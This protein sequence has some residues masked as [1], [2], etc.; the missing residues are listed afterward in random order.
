[1][2]ELQSW[3]L[4][5]Y[6]TSNVIENNWITRQLSKEPFGELSDSHL[7]YA[8][9]VVKHKFLVGL[10]S[11]LE[12]SMSRFEKFFRWKYHVNPIVQ[13]ACREHLIGRGANSNS[14]NIKERPIPGDPLWDLIANQNVY[15]IKLYQYIESL[16]E[17]QES[18][19]MGVPDNY[20]SI[21]STCCQCSTATYPPEGFS[22][23]KRVLR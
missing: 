5:K 19:F 6:A 8:I 23:P 14:K 2:P 16:Y 1:M 9:E 12:E 4:E 21:E 7:K 18:I 20:R 15:D 13:E 11:K 3:T 10:L 17:L 22:C